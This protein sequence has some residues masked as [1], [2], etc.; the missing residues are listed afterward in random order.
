MRRWRLEDAP[1]LRSTRGQPHE[2]RTCPLQPQVREQRHGGMWGVTRERVTQKRPIVEMSNNKHHLLTSSQHSALRYNHIHSYTSLHLQY[3]RSALAPP[4]TVR[5]SRA[6][7][8]QC[9]S[10]TYTQSKDFL[11]L[12]AKSQTASLLVSNSR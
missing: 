3:M 11:K 1:E 2:R 8:C 10:L 4:G 5:I 12:F 7:W 9:P 6:L